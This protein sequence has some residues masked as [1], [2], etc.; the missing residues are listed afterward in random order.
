MRQ[1]KYDEA[2]F[3]DSYSRM[4]RSV[5]GLNAA[6]EWHELQTLLPDLKQKHVL[7]LGCGFGWHCRYAREQQ[8]KSVIGVDLSEN[9]L[10]RARELTD[11]SQIEY[12]QMAIEDIHF[13]QNR[14]DVVISSLALHYVEHI[15][16]VFAKI[17]HCLVKGGTLV[18]SVEHPIF[19][20]R[21]EQDWHYGPD[22]EIL[23][24]PVDHYH[25]EG[26]R[27]ANFLNQDVVKYHRTLATYINE[28]VRAGFIIQQVA[29]SKPSPEMM[30]QVPGMSDENRRPMFLMIAAMKA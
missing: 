5:E 23:H 26:Q 15:D 13:E 29:E 11:D 19:T 10:R 7:D 20:A 24:W 25:N 21:A 27:T 18:L 17:H 3:F 6:G 1:N 12:Q 16:E 14:F 2:A 4:S 9:M 28:L 30:E 22:G 8:A